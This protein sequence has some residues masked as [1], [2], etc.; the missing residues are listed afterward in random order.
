MSTVVVTGA[1][2]ELGSRVLAL[3]ADDPSVDRLVAVDRRE[4]AAPLPRT[5]VVCVDLNRA[6]LPAVFAGADVVVHLAS[7]TVPPADDSTGSDAHMA[8]C[9]LAAAVAAGV[10]HV[11]VRSSATV[12][13]A[14]A[15][16]PVP[17]TEDAPLRPEQRF[18]WAGERA[19]IERLVAEWLVD[20]ADTTAT[21]LRPT[22]TVGD[23]STSWLAEA[24]RAT[25]LIRA[26]DQDDPPLQF[27]HIDDLAAAT[28]IAR[29]R[30]IDG[31]VNVAPDG[32]VPGDTV[33]AL[34]GGGVRL[35]LPEPVATRFAA[36]RWHRQLA[37]TP[38]GL[39]PYTQHPWVI[40]NDKLTAAGWKPEYT[41]EEA[42]V[43][44]HEASPWA[45]LS[46]RR[47]QE[48]ALGVAGGAAL[49]AIGGTVA[50]LRRRSRQPR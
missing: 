49:A 24:L 4:I 39:V 15:N 36:W 21:L 45:D 19:D 2:G 23:N 41:N 28:D 7:N 47:R 11:V 8:K 46:P 5:E 16:N 32:W 44:G 6:D 9:M 10:S 27:L 1:A 40:S 38:P 22:T 18:G 48:L 42:Y 31:A 14:R 13:G 33:R 3:V 43:A 34:A 25:A 35:R 20:R 37:P 12:Y 50:A 29:V 26:G 30:R 17:L